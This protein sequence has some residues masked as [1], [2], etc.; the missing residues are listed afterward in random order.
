MHEFSICERIVDAVLAELGR[1]DPPP[2]R[3]LGVRVVVGRLHQI[4]PDYLE[5]AYASLTRDTAAAGSRLELRFVPIGVACR[6]CGWRGDIEP[7]AFRCGGCGALEVDV[8]SGRELYLEHL[9]VD[10]EA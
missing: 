5:F 8:V 1:L 6:A 2:G 10:A 7:P 3:L 4:V 9:E